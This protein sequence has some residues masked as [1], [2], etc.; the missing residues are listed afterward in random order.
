MAFFIQE[1]NDL[2][3]TIIYSNSPWIKDPLLIK[4]PEKFRREVFYRVWKQLHASHGNAVLIKGPRR[5]GKT[6][7]QKQLM[8]DLIDMEKVPPKRIFY[9]TFDDVQIQSERPEHRAKMVY[10]ILNVWAKLLGYDTYD[11]IADQAYL[12]LDEVQAVSEWATLVK[13]RVE[14]NQNV[15]IVLSGSAAHSI[16]E[17]STKILLGRVISEKLTT[18]SFREFLNAGGDFS[19][20]IIEQL[21][22]IQRQFELNL[23]PSKL[24]TSLKSFVKDNNFDENQFRI[25]ITEY[26]NAGGFPQLWKMDPGNLV[27]KAH[28]IDEN[29]VKKVTLE[30]LMLLQQIKKPELYERLL[31]HLFARPGQ[32][33]NQNKTASTLG[34]TAVTL[35][36]AMKLLEQT[37][38]LIFVE[39]FSQKAEPL[40]R[41][42]LKIYPIDMILTFAMTKIQPSLNANTEKGVIAESLVAQTL[43]RL[44]GTSNI[45]YIRS[46][47]EGRAGELDFF[48]RADTRDCPIEVKYQNQLRS[49]DTIFLKNIIRE[50]GL[51][52]GLLINI[53]SWDDSEKVFGIPLWAFMLIA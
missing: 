50:R 18:F 14:R 52:G 23:S 44:R 38:L 4:E 10:D 12:F 31:R 22:E 49:E 25:H 51:E 47:A 32:E 6:E 43:V 37:D 7:I 34:T 39:K 30:D 48:L 3:H 9:L 26:I 27:E 53:D 40:R 19:E 5:V 29:Y 46:E 36:D 35:A 2:Y 24:A 28:L 33:Y 41:K 45:A 20:N 1:R 17:K 8:W 21:L 13:N 11:E 16:F 42:S 15:R